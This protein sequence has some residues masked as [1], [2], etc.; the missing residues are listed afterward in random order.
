MTF[1]YAIADDV[2]K[3]LR[4]ALT[5]D[6]QTYVENLIDEACDLIDGYLYPSVVPASTP[7]AITR[8][9]ADMVAAV[10]NRPK[11]VLPNTSQTAADIY[12][13]TFEAGT[14]NPGPYLTAAFKIR[15]DPYRFGKGMASIQLGSGRSRQTVVPYEVGS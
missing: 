10:F 4:R 14:T 15:L 12:S 8:V 11:G 5:S 1:P 9:A 3:S 13:V 7:G 6:E 2:V